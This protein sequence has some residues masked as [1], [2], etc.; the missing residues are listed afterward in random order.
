MEIAV[1]SM[2]P[3][4]FTI[5]MVHLGIKKANYIVWSF[6]KMLQRLEKL[7]KFHAFLLAKAV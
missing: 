4:L 1:D 7:E 2:L 6:E 5:A 3:Y